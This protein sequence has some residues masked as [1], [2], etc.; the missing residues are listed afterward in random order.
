MPAFLTSAPETNPTA[1]QEP[2]PYREPATGSRPDRLTF[3]HQIMKKRLISVLAVSLILLMLALWI[4]VILAGNQYAFTYPFLSA[5]L[6]SVLVSGPGLYFK[7]WRSPTFVVST[8]LL[9]FLF[10]PA[11]YALRCWPGG[12]DGPGMAWILFIVFGSRIAAILS[13]ALL[14]GSIVLALV[15]RKQKTEPAFPD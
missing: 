2:D 13:I 6:I 5:S 14:I 3:G 12:D 1:E 7:R 11:S 8:I 10:I 15:K 4:A 9:A